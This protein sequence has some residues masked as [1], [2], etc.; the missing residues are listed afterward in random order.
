MFKSK[1]FLKMIVTYFCI[2]I[3][4]LTMLGVLLSFLL[5]NYL[6]YNKQMEM[7]VKSS[8]ISELVRPFLVE[9]RDPAYLVD[10]LNRADKK[11]GT[12]IWVIDPRGGVI[13]ASA[14]QKM[15]EG[16]LIAQEDI[17]ELQQGKVSIRQGNSPVYNETVLWVIEPVENNNRVIGGVIVYSPII[18][19]TQTMIKVRNLFLYSAVVSL[20]FSTV[21]VY[22]LSKYVTGPLQD[23]NRVAQ[24][25]AC[26]KLTER[27]NIKQADEI[28]DLAKAFN[29]MAG[30]IEKQEKMRRDFVAD[31][32][33]ELRSPLTNIQGFIEAMMDGKDKTVEDRSRYLGIIHKE[34][35]RVSRLVIELLDLARFDAG[36]VVSDRKP[37]DIL[38]VVSNSINK[39]NPFLQE[40]NLS[41]VL[42][43]PEPYQPLMVNANQDRIEQVITNL[44]DN[45]IRYAPTASQIQ[46]NVRLENG[47]V[48]VTVADQGDGI[49]AEDIPLIWERFYKVDKSRS[50][51]EGGTGLG[52][53]IV[54]KIV[55]SFGGQVRVASERG[56]GTEIG[57]DLP[58][59]ENTV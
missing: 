17:L 52:L 1:L 10:L 3:S 8:D 25:L 44:L 31:V 13:A 29:Y 41:L 28:G 49:I 22:F 54:K 51:G 27:V 23:M 47:N 18:G 11:L 19:I 14:D 9:K 2:I 50:R 6:V 4:T 7:L 55:E 26:G 56:Q 16:D 21:V 48:A 20:I 36:T 33:H 46:I 39:V 37:M 5:N 45:A 32:S 53:A 12:E 35:L 43:K 42:N 34:T 30:Q 38:D 57:F 58:V 15:H 40:K 24:Q 59:L